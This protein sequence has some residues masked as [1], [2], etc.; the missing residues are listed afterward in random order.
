[1]KIKAD[2]EV[3]FE[4]VETRS[5]KIFEGYRPS[6]LIKD[7]Y[8]TT[9]IHSYYNLNNDS[10]DKLMGTITFITPEEYPNCLWKGKKIAMYEGSKLIGYATI[11]NIFNPILINKEKIYRSKE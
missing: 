1:M 9:G 4:F 2:I 3:I 7:G 8:F 11:L 6:H 5:K 10:D